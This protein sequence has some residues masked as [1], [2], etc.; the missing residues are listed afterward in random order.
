MSTRYTDIENTGLPAVPDL[1][2]DAEDTDDRYEYLAE[3]VWSHRQTL[4]QPTDPR[5]R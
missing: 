3:A 2:T 1:R 4:D 5:S